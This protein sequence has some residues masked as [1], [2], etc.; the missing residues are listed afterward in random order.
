MIYW[1]TIIYS[2]HICYINI[3]IFF[4]IVVDQIYTYSR[5]VCIR[6][7]K[8]ASWLLFCVH[9]CSG[10]HMW[11]RHNAVIQLVSHP[12]ST[13]VAHG[14]RW[15]LFTLR[16]TSFYRPY[17]TVLCIVVGQCQSV[18]HDNSGVYIISFPFCRL[19]RLWEHM[20]R[21]LKE[22]NL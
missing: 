21:L 15:V 4:L 7:P 19:C 2:L 12:S 17:Q 6:L 22:P 14:F 1:S 9:I 16:Q 18:P 3:L 13:A 8:L 20:G 5:K 11:Q 10:Q